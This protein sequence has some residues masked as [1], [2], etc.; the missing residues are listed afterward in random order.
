MVAAA[1]DPRSGTSSKS[2]SEDDESIVNV[3]CPT[4]RSI[5]ENQ[6]KS[7]L[8]SIFCQNSEKNF[9]EAR[10]ELGGDVRGNPFGELNAT[11]TEMARVFAEPRDEALKTPTAPIVVSHR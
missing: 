5:F 6:A 1:A 4:N 10:S 9:A 11:E 7:Y 8:F 2:S 3:R